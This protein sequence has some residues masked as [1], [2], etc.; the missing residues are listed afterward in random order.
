MR[1]IVT[2]MLPITSENDSKREERH[3]NEDQ[4]D[5]SE[6]DNNKTKMKRKQIFYLDA[7]N[8]Y[9]TTMSDYP[10]PYRGFK[11]AN[12]LYDLGDMSYKYCQRKLTED[13][14]VGYVLEVDL[15]YPTELHDEHN[16]YPLAPEQITIT[17]DHLSPYQKKIA[18]KLDIKLTST[19]KKLCATLN[20]KRWYVVYYKNL[21]FYMKQGMLLR[22]VHRV[23]M[24]KIAKF[25]K[26]YV[27]FITKMRKKRLG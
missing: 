15:D 4:S 14:N 24:F 25:L 7:N 10:L 21:L 2:E 27:D 5:N 8:F 16:S 18:D 12:S 19:N 1:P 13:D 6:R 11:W 22:N 20:N 26:I 9:Q 17:K 23:I 3:N